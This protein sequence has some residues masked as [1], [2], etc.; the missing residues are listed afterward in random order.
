VTTLARTNPLVK[1]VCAIGFVLVVVLVPEGPGPKQALLMLPLLVAWALAG[2][3][4]KPVAGRLLMALPFVAAVL[5]LALVGPGR[6]PAEAVQIW[7]G[8]HLSASLAAALV[9]VVRILLCVTALAIL[10]VTTTP[11]A[12]FGVLRMLHFPRLLCTTLAFTLRY[13][14]TLEEEAARM[15]RAR[16]S[17]GHGA[18]V[19]VARRARVAGCMI[20][21]LMVRSWERAGRVSA[22]M[23][24]RGFTGSLPFRAGDPPRPVEALAGLGFLGAAVALAIIKV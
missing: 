16:D 12:L 23:L 1:C 6:S 18:K 20:G 13:A 17:R 7:P 2:A 9:R 21:T 15:M 11:E 8:V 14:H 24:A 3:P 5:A 10:A 19:G 4:V 22:A